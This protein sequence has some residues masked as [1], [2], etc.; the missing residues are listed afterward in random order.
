[1]QNQFCRG[2]SGAILGDIGTDVYNQLREQLVA[3]EIMAGQ[4]LREESLAERFGVSRTPIREALRRLQVEGFIEIAP[5]RGARVLGWRAEDIGEVFALRGVLEPHA[6]RQ[7]ALRLSDDDLVVARKLADGM[8]RFAADRPDGF[9]DQIASLN[10]QFHALIVSGSG[11]YR[12]SEQ[13]QSIMELA[14]VRAT[15][16]RYSTHE[17]DR[18]MSHHRE[19]LDALAARDPD[20]AES[21]MKCHIIAA[22]SVY[23]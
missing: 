3:G 5:H 1:M 10:N 18:S 22:R 21:V 17:L 9:E 14:R 23:R 20:W 16:Q 15:F 11:N 12:L 19:L 13:V 2:E 4:L 6:A 8:E 7:A